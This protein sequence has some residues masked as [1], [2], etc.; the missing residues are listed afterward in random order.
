MCE[1]PDLY[2]RFESCVEYLYRLLESF[3]VHELYHRFKLSV[4]KAIPIQHVDEPC[5]D[6]PVIRVS[7]HSPHTPLP[8]WSVQGT[9]LMASSSWNSGCLWWIPPMLLPGVWGGKIS[10]FE[11]NKSGYF[12]LLDHNNFGS[13]LWN[14][15]YLL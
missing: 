13:R 8:P 11:K 2:H 1:I 12:L 5:N 14:Q 6:K 3:C 7:L 9:P 15:S 4:E 10:L